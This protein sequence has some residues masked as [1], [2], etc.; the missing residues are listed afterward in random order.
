MEL[1]RLGGAPEVAAAD[2][3]RLIRVGRSM[4]NALLTKVEKIDSQRCGPSILLV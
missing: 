3:Q 2:A 1:R 4:L